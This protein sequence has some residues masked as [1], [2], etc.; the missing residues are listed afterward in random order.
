MSPEA[1]VCAST[2]ATR[3]TCE[4]LCAVSG[5]GKYAPSMLDDAVV[6]YWLP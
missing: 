4:E 5:G 6:A 1:A 2:D 3:A